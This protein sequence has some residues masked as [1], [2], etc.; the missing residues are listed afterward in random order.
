[1]RRQFLAILITGLILLTGAA[2]TD[3]IESF[4]IKPED[5][6]K[7]SIGFARDGSVYLEGEFTKT[8]ASE[9]TA[10]TER[11]LNKKL[12]LVINGKVVR[13][14]IIHARITG[15]SFILELKTIDEG[16]LLAKYLMQ[17]IPNQA[18][19]AIAP[20]GGAQPQR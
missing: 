1:M 2:W 15:G 16:V 12:R 9:F 8:K 11:N 10:A 3:D 4:I 13:E 14:P 20:Q 18:S 17:E 19:E 7:T 5:V 6:T